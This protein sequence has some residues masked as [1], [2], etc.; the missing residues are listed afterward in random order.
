MFKK[1]FILAI[2]AFSFRIDASK[3]PVESWA[4]IQDVEGDQ[5]F[6]RKILA[7][8]ENLEFL[9]RGKAE[10]DCYA[11][12]VADEKAKKLAAEVNSNRAAMFAKLFAD[13]SPNGN[14]SNKNPYEN[15][16]FGS[17]RRRNNKLKQSLH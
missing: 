14:Q 1:I 15:K 11:M 13:C 6:Y 7:K 5:S 9:L 17:L 4:N 12:L 8:D 16:G 2:L 3:V 10:R